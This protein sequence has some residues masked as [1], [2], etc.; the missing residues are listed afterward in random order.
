M[1]ALSS[2]PCSTWLGVLFDRYDSLGGALQR[3]G[4]KVFGIPPFRRKAELR[5]DFQW[6]FPVDKLE[7]YREW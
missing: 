1:R 2:E 4:H 6:Y 5:L 3:A 7:R